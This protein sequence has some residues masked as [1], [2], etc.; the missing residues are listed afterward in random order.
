MFRGFALVV[1]G[2]VTLAVGLLGCNQA[3]IDLT[4]QAKVD[5][6]DYPHDGKMKDPSYHSSRYAA[7]A[8]LCESCHGAD[9]SGGTANVSC[10]GCHSLHASKPTTCGKC[11]SEDKPTQSHALVSTDCSTCHNYSTGMFSQ[12]PSLTSSFSASGHANPAG[13]FSGHGSQSCARCHN[14]KGFRDYIGDDGSTEF[15]T[16]STTFTVPGPLDCT[17]CHNSKT[18]TYINSGVGLKST[19]GLTMNANREGF[20][21]ACHSGRT[22]EGKLK[23]ERPSQARRRTPR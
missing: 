12:L 14:L 1:L 18:D 23:I 15:L 9:L 3:K 8:S 21:V 5:V 22:G 10:V 19:S 4:Q 11:H 16:E 2:S 17:A 6:S 20:C 13:A 7:N